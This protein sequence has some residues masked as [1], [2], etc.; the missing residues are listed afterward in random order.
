MSCPRAAVLLVDEPLRTGLWEGGGW[1]ERA[2]A[3]TVSADE[4]E[5]M[6]K[7]ESCPLGTPVP[8]PGGMV[9]QTCNPS[10]LRG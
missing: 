2:S 8:S 6:G 9:V 3:V 7:V 5:R 4:D 10:T 1:E